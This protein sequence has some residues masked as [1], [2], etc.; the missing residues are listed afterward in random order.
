[1]T[2]ELL[3]FNG[4]NGATGG[5]GLAPMAGEKFAGLITGTDPPENGKDLKQRSDQSG[6]ARIKAQIAPL[7]EELRRFPEGDARAQSILAEIARLRTEL[8]K[9][10]HL[11]VIEGV[12]AKNLAQA[13]WG[14]IFP[15][16]VDPAVREALQPLLDLR[17][18]QAGDRFRL[19]EGTKCWR[20]GE[21][22]TQFLVRNGASPSG[23]A[24]PA[25]V[26]Y[27][28][29]IVA[30][31]DEI[32]YSFQYQLDVQYAVGRIHFETA[33][34]YAG[35]ARAVVAAEVEG[36][37]RAR[38]LSFFGV[39]N[40]GD[41]ATDL[42]SKLLV[43][44]LYDGLGRFG[45]GWEVNAV[46]GEGANR[47]RLEKLLG[48]DETPALL[49]TASHG[50]EFPLGD[51]RQLPHQGALLCG[52]W[53]GPEAWK[54]KG[55]I[56]ED[57]YFAGDHIAAGAD[58]AGM[59]LFCF[60]CYGG[61]TPQN[62]E[63]ARQA[64]KKQQAIAPRPFLS[65]LPRKLLGRGALAVIGHVDRAWGCSFSGTGPKARS[66]TQTFQSTLTRLLNGGQ[67]GYALDY[68]N[69]RYAENST[70]L[71]QELDEIDSGEVADLVAGGDGGVSEADEV[72]GFAGACGADEA[73]VLGLSD[74]LECDEVVV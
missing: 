41:A 63:F 62:D 24:D 13:G 9:Y 21:S 56:P 71:S 53:P 18:S 29:L 46:T 40:P 14:A 36:V 55:P 72:V 11:G 54:G 47:A 49:F 37:K 59:V 30:G 22:K 74:P 7:E 64:F 15:K 73:E 68:F 70:E 45:Q 58:V 25:Q 48:G 67:V 42:S 17:K 12:D 44:P 52:D 50:M 31:P 1:M 35:Y 32:P 27:Y 60:A 33:E 19:Y 38:R 51:A 10:E 6:A 69:E 4:V 3:F 61:G 2:G 23:P 20:N 16:N 65:A 8:R 26:P 34:E 28:L 43:A 57:H 66:Y 39:Q 5:Y